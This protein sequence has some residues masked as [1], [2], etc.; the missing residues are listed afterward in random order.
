MTAPD[1]DARYRAAPGGLFGD[2]PNDYL[3]MLW[4][5][6][7]FRPASALMLADGDGRNG[8]WVA[9]RGV[10]VS[11][12]DISAE[13]TRRGMARDAAAGVRVARITADLAA[14]HPA[15][16]QG[17]EMASLLY[18]HGPAMLRARAVT[19]AAAALVA[20]GWFVLEGFSTA[21]AAE[22]GM[23]PD[24]PEKLYDLAGVLALLPGFTVHEAL[25]GTVR[26]AEGPRH[27]GAASVVRVLARRDQPSAR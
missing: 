25:A 3:R 17:W 14:W 11:A 9:G 18:L 7:D 10:A 8:A 23:G 27:A 21:Q 4:A 6:L 22:P 12:V 15:P 5:R 24:D 13:A 20:G 19:T 1:W 26:L 2:A 16:G